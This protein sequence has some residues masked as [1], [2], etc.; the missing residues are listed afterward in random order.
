MA[1]PRFKIKAADFFS[2][3]SE[4]FG[5]TDFRVDAQRCRFKCLV[6]AG[7]HK[8]CLQ[9]FQQSCAFCSEP[10]FRRKKPRP[11][12]CY[13]NRRRWRSVDRGYVY[14]GA[15]AIGRPLEE[16]IAFIIE[17]QRTVAEEIGLQG[18]WPPSNQPPA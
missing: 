5:S 3:T 11:E 13:V 2:E 6:E 18:H 16:H 4:F 9:G 12:L 10:G 1:R 15:E 8:I 7:T 14:G 17:S